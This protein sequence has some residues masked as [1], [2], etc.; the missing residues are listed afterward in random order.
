MALL[1]SGGCADKAVV[2]C[3]EVVR[4]GHAGMLATA[5]AAAAEVR[6]LTRRGGD[7]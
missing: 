7:C 4:C 1:Y 3:P 2:P 5:L 6:G